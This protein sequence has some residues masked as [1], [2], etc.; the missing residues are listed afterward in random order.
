ML[1]T[2]L[3]LTCPGCAGFLQGGF[4]PEHDVG[5]ITNPFLQVKILQL[6]RVLGE[7]ASCSSKHNSSACRQHAPPLSWQHLIHSC[8]KHVCEQN[9]Q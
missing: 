2:A 3:A 7:Q 1:L 4:S 5:G 9:L 6:L 8:C